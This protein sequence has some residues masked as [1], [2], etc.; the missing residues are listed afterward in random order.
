MLTFP[1]H[2]CNLQ[3][4]YLQ[5]SKRYRLYYDTGWTLPDRSDFHRYTCMATSADGKN[6]TKPNLGVATFMNPP[7]K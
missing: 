2:F 4:Y 7:E 5:P 6:W 3:R 1:R